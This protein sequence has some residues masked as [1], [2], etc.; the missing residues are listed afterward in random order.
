MEDG[1]AACAYLAQAA[2]AITV[3]SLLPL[4]FSGSAP[5][6][7]AP[8]LLPI[9]ASDSSAAPTGSAPFVSSLFA[10]FSYDR[11]RVSGA[12][13]QFEYN[14][15]SGSISS[16]L[17]TTVLDP[18]MYMG[19]IEISGFLPTRAPTILGPIFDAQGMQVEVTAHDD[20]TGLLMVR[21]DIARTVTIRL[22]ASA[23]N[24]TQHSA[25]HAWPASSMSYEIGDV[26]ARLV[27][28]AGTFDLMGTT[29]TARMA[30]TD[31]LIF[32]AVPEASPNRAE[33][34]AVLD[35]IAT[36]QLVAE[37]EMIATHDGQWLQNGAHYRNDLSVV[38]LAVTHGRA[39]V[40]LA[41]TGSGG[42]VVLLAFDDATMPADAARK[43]TVRAN[44]VVVNRTADTLGLFYTPA[45][46]AGVSTYSILPL[47]GT[48]IALYLPSLAPTSI[49]VESVAASPPSVSFQAD[50]A[51]AFM[52][53]VIVVAGAAARIFRRR[54]T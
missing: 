15:A 26:Q 1:R 40:D 52:L 18:T 39:S 20:P 31:L 54:D 25:Q 35:A 51:L 5:S 23:A 9:S 3:L 33:W 50:S 16:Y 2:A 8:A 10:S 48:V 49:D 44:G 34:R 21:T 47:P 41:C 17:S 13:I 24:L 7:G 30:A 32:K 29:I 46:K 53:A 27:L 11:G 38:P 19:S 4:A 42:A 28:G 45:T 36:G 43:F 12:Y 14:A 37:L 6:H 22:P